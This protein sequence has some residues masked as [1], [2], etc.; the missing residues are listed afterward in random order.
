MET[1]SEFAVEEKI[2]SVNEILRELEGTKIPR[3][4]L[5]HKVD[6]DVCDTIWDIYGQKELDEILSTVKE[7]TYPVDGSE[8]TLAEHLRRC[9]HSGVR[10]LINDF[11]GGAKRTIYV[12]SS[13]LESEMRIM[14]NKFVGR[15]AYTIFKS[16]SNPE[17][18]NCVVCELKSLNVPGKLKVILYVTEKESYLTVITGKDART[19]CL[20][21]KFEEEI[22]EYLFPLL[23]PKNIL[24][25]CSSHNSMVILSKGQHL[26]VIEELIIERFALIRGNTTVKLDNLEK[27]ISNYRKLNELSRASLY[28]TKFST[29]A[30]GHTSEYEYGIMYINT[31]TLTVNYKGMIYKI[32]V[33]GNIL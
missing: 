7:P 23:K 3:G 4:G 21:Y 15:D 12:E 11:E 27:Y 14:I 29:L 25:L 24:N 32:D 31:D 5:I 16:Y 26:E 18:R 17:F 30:I 9:I 1:T 19:F 13:R 8:Y 6:S 22:V 10:S 2:M 28:N 20:G 33:M